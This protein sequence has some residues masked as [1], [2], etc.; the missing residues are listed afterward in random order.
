MKV[1][2]VT[3]WNTNCGMAYFSRYLAEALNTMIDVNIVR[4][5]PS[6]TQ[7]E[8]ADAISSCSGDL[9]HIEHEWG[10][11]NG[12]EYLLLNI[13]QKKRIPV[14]M[15]CHGGGYHQFIGHV[16]KIAVPNRSQRNAV[17]ND[18]LV[19]ILPHGV[20]VYPKE[21]KA[22]A[23]TRLGITKEHVVTQWGFI[24]PHKC[25]ELTLHAIKDRDDVCFLIA[26]SEER[27]FEY[28][29]SLQ[30]LIK[31]LDVHAEIVKTG[32]LK[33]E[34]I[35][36]VFGATDVCVFPY[37][38]GVDSGC[39]RYALG[40]HVVSLASPAPFIQEL[41]KEYGVPYI[42]RDPWNQHFKRALEQLL[43]KTDV[44]DFERRCQR[45]ADAVSWINV[46]KQHVVVYTQVLE[47]AQR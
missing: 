9:V 34:N 26:G 28:W 5:D 18:A 41:F 13:L 22:N 39:L 43:R 25:Y 47:E 23:R 24:L 21:P 2:L 12:H 11:Y 19:P 42:V 37:L 15:T 20:T 33:E 29:L 1:D 31:D 10:I 8:F 32:F 40:S 44:A 27:N 38:T 16:A 4:V 3:T 30:K 45:F 14:I 17:M 7:Q 36:L 46:A 6:F 35:P